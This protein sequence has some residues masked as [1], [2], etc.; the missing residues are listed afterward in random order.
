LHTTRWNRF[1]FS[2]ARK[3]V[4]K[5]IR[6]SNLALEELESR[7]TPS[8]AVLTYHNDNLSTG[9][10]LT[11]TILTPSNVNA[12][13]F[14]KLFST[15]VDGQVYAQPLYDPG[16]NIATGTNQ[17]THNVVFIAT[18]HDSLYAID[19]NNGTILWHD[20]LLHAVHGGTVT[21][22]PN[23]DVNSSDISPEIGVTATP[24][25][26]ASSGILYIEAKT[27]EVASDGSHYI[28]QLYAVN[29]GN[30]SFVNG[31]PIVIADSIGDTYLSGPTDKGSGAGSSG[32]TVFFDAL[33]QMERPGLTEA[34]GNIYLAFASHGDNG[35]YHGWVLSYKAS[36]LALNGVFDAT[37]NGSEGGIWQ[38]GGRVA[39]D[40]SGNLYFETG[41]G[42]FDT[43]LNSSGL[44]VNGDYGDS[45]VKIAV[46]TTTSPTNQNING[47]GLKAVDY[48]TP[49]DQANLN[50]GDLDLGSGGPLLLPDAAGSTA[51]SHLMVGAGKEGRI[52]LI[53]RDN[54][55]HFSSSTDNVV[56]ETNNTTIT[57]SFDTPAYFNGRIY[58]VGGSNIG[59]PNDVGK[60]FSI[61]NG[62]MSLTPTSQG[63]DSYAYPGDTPSISANGTSNGIVWAQDTGTS[64]L[65]AY[66]ATGFNTE[67]YTS[68][69]AAGNRDTLTGSV[70]K[71]AV[72]TVADG[73]VFV[74][75][76]NALNVFGLLSQA[77]QAPAAPSNL[78]ALALSGT[79]IQ[80]TWKD[81]STAPN[82]ATGFDI[83][84]SSNGVNFTQ[85]ATAGAGSTSFTVGGLQTSTTYTFRIRAFNAIGN[86]AYSNTAS[87]TTSQAPTLNFSSGF[88]NAGSLLTFNGTAKVNGTALQ[89]TDGG[90]NEAGSAFSTGKVDVT[91]FTTQFSF[92]LT[93]G[94]ST[95]DGFTFCIQS[96]GA[97]A[98][99][100]TGGGLGYGPDTTGGTGGIFTSV[101]IK[102]DL[103]NNQG[104]GT[105]STGLYTN[106]AA[107]T[108]V[109][110]ID[111]TSTGIN[112]HSGDTINVSMTYDGTA[113]TVTETDPTVNKTATQSYTINISSTVGSGTA[114]V[115]FTGGTGG[116]TATQDILTWTY[117]PTAT[118]TAPAAP[119][120]LTAT[121][122]SATQVNLTWTNNATNQTG[123][124][125]DRATDSA[126]TQNL[127][128]QTAAASA[129]SFV[130]SG[131]TTGTTY[132]YRVRAF[133]AVG[134][135]ANSNTASV[136]T[137]TLPAP[138]SN[139]HVTKVTFNEIDL[140][141]TNNATN[142]TSIQVFR[143]VGGNNP[144]LIASLS[145]TTTSLA[146]AGLVVALQ[147]GTTYTYNVQA[148][149]AAG[150]SSVTS[151][152]ATTASRV[153]AIACGNSAVS[154]FV[155]DT[156]F[157]GGTVSHGTTATIN[158]SHVSNPA[159]QSVWQHGRYGNITYTIPNLTA[160][161]LYAVQLDFV[162]YIFSS[163]G[164]RVFNVAINGTQVL[165]NFDIFVA[166]GGENIALAK[167]FTATAS[168]SGIITITFTS[169][170]NNSMINGIEIYTDPP[171]PAVN[172][173]A[174]FGNPGGLTL[175]GSAKV[176][177]TA[178]QLTDGGMNEAASAFTSSAVNVANF[179][180]SFSFQ[181]VNPNADGFTF[182]IQGAS[183][184]ALGPVGGG[185]GYGPDTTGG[186]G[187][188]STSVAIKFDLY[189]NQGEGTDS[190]GLYTN[191]A[192]PTDFGSIDLTNTGINLHS[193]DVFNVGLTYDGTTLVE[194]ITDASTGASVTE[195]YVVNIPSLVG[196]DQAF[197]GFTGGT[198]GLT[199]T[200]DILNWSYS[201]T[202]Q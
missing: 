36:T 200:Q 159:P 178:L 170:V 143:Q 132:Y 4:R 57:G 128:T 179:S 138:V 92:Q 11:E 95:A 7:V 90:N 76:S 135:S 85:V 93:A 134:D 9:Q 77:T 46:D 131:L 61:A 27:K 12:N 51:H 73:L 186:T 194:K 14:G 18:Q 5:P 84:Q 3:S 109:G 23:G 67:L 40:A 29:I 42:T 108:N 48:F 79:S 139:L 75:T 22:V 116:Q 198:G 196:G 37:P 24:T 53:D 156:D 81:N 16:V 122:A 117:T 20:T 182:T 63:P 17:G 60:T 78:A 96:A 129:T 144:I 83:E 173:A 164:Q 171:A 107:P 174:G 188:I 97:T 146:D 103:Y 66:N 1:P 118:A 190:T 121:A 195:S 44:P 80:L 113:L 31:S 123:F 115:G 68:A 160:G 162:E 8:T 154:P 50:N 13:T 201:T 133:N 43:T 82:T 148:M 65:R 94:T 59:N 101:A 87:A 124:H 187:G 70:V 41:N 177:G 10:N 35:P 167:T 69:Q 62:Q 147:P 34:N 120:N 32:G 193:G 151:V 141:W 15:S 161:A 145:P 149:N 6:R 127:V 125:I 172:F 197:V 111:L 185:L 21:S 54:M 158:T 191:G 49:F 52:Y 140:S 152:S 58:Y 202:T 119:S 28:H 47:W 153:L 150:P 88:A 165:S 199:T 155:A 189:N 102:F 112:L 166:A 183:P 55:G 89:L 176:N 136:T 99:G 126:F 180:T 163:S 56:Q 45:F 130:D 106:G 33:R 192:A 98:L 175:N 137:P 181:L 184:T 72:P 26:D 39:V 71:F 114:F 91:H 105:D 38:S 168:S 169:V 110:S 142:A 74:G 86:S 104:E 30:G 64:Q 19:A 100:P 157:S 25:I 2:R